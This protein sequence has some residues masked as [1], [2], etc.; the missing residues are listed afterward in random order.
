[1]EDTI[2]QDKQKINNDAKK[3]EE[4]KSL[5]ETGQVENSETSEI[6]EISEIFFRNS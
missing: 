3:T 5:Q 6:T 2:K 1:M 4:G